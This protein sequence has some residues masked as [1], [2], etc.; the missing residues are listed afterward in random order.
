[1]FLG[2]DCSTQQ[3]KAVVIDRHLRIRSETSVAFD[4][5]LSHYKTKNGV[6]VDGNQV[7]S[8]YVSAICPNQGT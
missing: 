3:L 7:L 8:P 1:M 5:D 4:R 6:Y 2:L